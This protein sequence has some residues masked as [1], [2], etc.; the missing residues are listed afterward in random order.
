MVTAAVLAWARWRLLEEARLR[1][2][3]RTDS[4][5]DFLPWIVRLSVGLV[6]IGAGLSRALSLPILEADLVVLG[7]GRWS[8]DRVLLARIGD[9]LR[10]W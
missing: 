7:G 8:V 4:Y 9:C 2:I 5:H 10:R 3:E 1:F 6:L